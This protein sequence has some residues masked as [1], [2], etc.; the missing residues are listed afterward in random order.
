MSQSGLQDLRLLSTIDAKDL[1]NNKFSANVS[2]WELK[3]YAWPKTYENTAGPFSGPGVYA[4][5]AFTTFT[6][7][8]W[9]TGRFTVVFCRGKVLD[10]REDVD[11]F[12]PFDRSVG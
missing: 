7:E 8:A 5:Q 2:S 3:Y 12:N 10:I 1:I 4:G 6:L 11:G 9:S